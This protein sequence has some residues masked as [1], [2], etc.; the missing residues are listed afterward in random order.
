[1]DAPRLD[2]ALR[3]FRNALYLTW[4]YLGL[5]EPT[6]LQYD[7]ANFLQTG[8]DGDRLLMMAYRGMG[9]TYI[10]TAWCV[11][12]H[13][14]A[15]EDRGYSDL[16][17]LMTSAGK[18]LADLTSSF[19]LKL[20]RE[21]PF[22]QCLQPG[23]GDLT[24]LIKFDV[25]GKRPA[26]DP[27]F[28]SVG[29]FGQSTGS[30]ANRLLLDDLEV[31]NTAGTV[32]MREK[33]RSRVAGLQD[34]LPPEGGRMIC[35]GTPH[36][37]QSLYAWL[38]EAGGFRARIYPARYPSVER[39]A[40]M[41]DTLAPPIREALEADPSLA[42]APTDPTRFD[43]DE[44][45]QRE[46]SAGRSHFARQYD[47]DTSLTDREAH[48]LRLADLIVHDVD[49]EVSPE[50]LVWGSNP[51]ESLPCW[52]LIGDRFNRA[53]PIPGA[54]VVPY[55]GTV[56][57]IDPSGRGKDETAFAVAKIVNAQVVVADFGGYL[58]GFEDVTLRS[59]A[60]TAKQWGVNEIIVESNYGGGMFDQLLKPHL[61]AEGHPCTVTPL[62]SSGQKER[63][64]CDT[65]EPL[66]GQHRVVVDANALR[67]DAAPR[68]G[69]S[70][71]QAMMYRLAYQLSHVTRERGCLRHD[72]RLEVLAMAC[73]YWVEHLGRSV[74]DAAKASR[75]D[76]MEEAFSDIIPNVA[77]GNWNHS[78]LPKNL[79]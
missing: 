32:G 33:L 73:G 39:A 5:P 40:L 43:E 76:A 72:D 48:P 75:R 49:P 46:A 6:P 17:T 58:A 7:M 16:H 78:I 59:L 60:R 19:A 68:E 64:I 27:S 70:E 71:E 10:S 22:Y 38:Q 35:L 12:E 45:R 54:Q 20:I 13:R 55:T 25:A 8:Q 28:K 47:L 14:L 15:L 74:E 29:I 37:E 77:T 67:R 3:D 51:D 11:H 26:K 57:A 50:R 4:Q 69:V 79:Q 61:Q 36:F 23:P 56:M 30:R 66:L 41:G 42:G 52:G 21:V 62:R 44:L 63:R 1:M 9:K 24:S 2:P 65:L 31:P 53:I 18:D 34:L